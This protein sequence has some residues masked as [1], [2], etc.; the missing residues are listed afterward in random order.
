MLRD[1]P[2]SFAWTL[3]KRSKRKIKSIS[4]NNS[5]LKTS[6]FWADDVERKARRGGATLQLHL[7]GW[8]GVCE[9]VR[10]H[11]SDASQKE[12]WYELV[13]GGP[14]FPRNKSAHLV[15]LQSLIIFPQGLAHSWQFFLRQPI[16]PTTWF[17]FVCF[18]LVFLLVLRVG[19]V[20]RFYTV[21]LKKQAEELA[22]TVEERTRDLEKQRAFLSQII[23]INPNVIFVKD[24]ESRYRLVNQALADAYFTTKEE[25]VGKCAEDF[26]PYQEDA[27]RFRQHDQETIRAGKELISP[28]EKVTTPGGE[29]RWI[30]TIRRPIFDEHGRATQVLGVTIEITQRKKIEEEL[31]AAKEVAEAA[32]RAKSGFLANMSHE[33]RTPMNGIIGM[34]ELAMTSQGEEQ[35]EYLSLLRSSANALLVILND[36]LD[37]SKIEAGKLE[38]DPVRFDLTELV[39]DVVKSMTFTAHKKNLQLTFL[40]E[41]DVPAEVVADQ[42]RLRQVLI[43]LIGNA[44][45]FTDKGSIEIKLRKK[46]DEKGNA[47][48]LCVS[49]HDT[50]IGVAPEKQKRLFHAFEQADSS[51][52]RQYGGTGLGLAICSRIVQLMGGQIWME[53]EP[54]VG[55]TFYFTFQYAAAPANRTEA[56]DGRIE[57]TRTLLPVQ[58]QKSNAGRSLNILLVE[59]S[60]VN[61]RLAMAMLGKMGHQV[62]LAVN[63]REAVEKWSQERFDL[64][65]MDI[66][67]PE[68]DGLEASRRIREQEPKGLRIPIIAMTAHAMNSD[69]ER[70]LAAGM[71]DHISKPV[72]RKTIEDALKH[73]GVE[74]ERSMREA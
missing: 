68:M 64:I 11:W 25:M 71:D 41:P 70:C 16:D 73:I 8:R 42:L 35:R 37:Y 50:G 66:Q 32:N 61:Q 62:T 55:S 23:D 14:P 60:P 44:V 29:V 17:Y 9:F 13:C 26:C 67:M 12:I 15:L 24:S 45:K 18:L 20:Q 21:E 10:S 30:Q 58:I 59:D 19:A 43:N 31:R 54:G 38:L 40:I 27:K 7:T 74:A 4:G 51:T 72:S 28:E 65:F 57:I 34:A 47:Q 36:I 3:Y 2:V 39:S 53:S 69:R 52:T 33:I 1:M 6:S 63:G 22:H 49:V 46:E 56:K 5:Q 48:K